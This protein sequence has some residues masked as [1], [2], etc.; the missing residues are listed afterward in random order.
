MLSPSVAY[1]SGYGTRVL[2]GFEMPSNNKT[3][4]AAVHRDIRGRRRSERVRPSATDS[5]LPPADSLQCYRSVVAVAIILIGAFRSH[6]TYYVIS[7]R[8]VFEFCD[9]GSFLGRAE[10]E[11]GDIH[12]FQITDRRADGPEA[13][14][15]GVA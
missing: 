3:Y 1:A 8:R 15:V 5:P 9:A 10:P 13:V 14:T 11:P 6:R 4:V 12:R 2:D 7:D